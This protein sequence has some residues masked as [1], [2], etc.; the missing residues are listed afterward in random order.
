VDC[1]RI[2]GGVAPLG[3]ATSLTRSD[4][5]GVQGRSPVGHSLDPDGTFRLTDLGAVVFSP[6]AI[7]QYLHNQVAAV[8]TGSFV[9]AAVGA[10]WTIRGQHAETARIS[11]RTGVIA[12][13][14]SSQL[15]AFPTGHEQGRMVAKHQPVAL[16]A[17]EGR[18]E[19]G[20]KAPVT[21]IG[22]PNVEE[23][24][25]DN[26]IHIPAVLSWLAYGDF[27]ANVRGLSDFPEK[28]WPGNIEL[29]IIIPHHGGPRRCSF[30]RRL[31]ANAAVLF[32]RYPVALEWILTL[33]FV[34]SS[35]T[36]PAG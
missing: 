21:M 6:W 19:G 2:G 4:H 23:R 27:S 10:Y 24:K 5:P 22:Q 28:D 15:V 34:H 7:T 29:P 8:V 36:S 9:M 17:M 3:P 35:P 11:L 12:A 32:R 18:F 25:I 14:V 1:V 33:A 16:A 13:L 31:H 30:C 26:P 20:N